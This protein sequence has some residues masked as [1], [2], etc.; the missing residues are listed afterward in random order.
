MKARVLN[1]TKTYGHHVARLKCEN[2]VRI[3]LSW[4][5]DEKVTVHSGFN[6][7]YIVSAKNGDV[8]KAMLRHIT[9]TD[10]E[11][12]EGLFVSLPEGF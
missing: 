9:E 5:N 8:L 10:L 2:G 4:F 7:P 12:F 6:D 11:T 1:L 3:D